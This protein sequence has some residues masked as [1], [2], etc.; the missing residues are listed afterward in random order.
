MASGSARRDYSSLDG[1]ETDSYLDVISMS[2]ATTVKATWH[3][4]GYVYKNSGGNSIT[5][6]SGYISVDGVV[7]NGTSGSVTFTLPSTTN[8]ITVH[9]SATMAYGNTQVTYD[10]NV[11]MYY[12]PITSNVVICTQNRYEMLILPDPTNI[13][14]KIFWIVNKGNT[15]FL[16]VSAYASETIDNFGNNQIQLPQW[17]CVSLTTNGTNWFVLSYYGGTFP[18]YGV[19]SVN[20][21]TPTSNILVAPIASTT[22]GKNIILPNPATWGKGNFFFANCYQT[23]TSAY[24]ISAQFAIYT[25]G[26]LPQN[27]TTGLYLSL[28]PAADDN[29]RYDHNTSIAFVS[30]GT[31]WY[32]ASYFRGENCIFDTNT[33]SAT[34]LTSGILLKTNTTYDFM[35]SAGPVSNYGKLYYAKLTGVKG[36]YGM[37]LNNAGNDTTRGYCG[38]TNYRRVYKNSS[39]QDYVSFT[40]I[41]ANDGTNMINYPVGMYPSAY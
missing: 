13:A 25:N 10:L 38:S 16:S 22:G 4:F 6:T 37:Y 30:D 20:G 31:S 17:G 29:S 7:T 33:Q 1:V 8:A 23:S 9:S 2:N 27:T 41:Q 24:S 21:T 12:T 36:T 34:E 19:Y 32:I 26:Y 35:P 28:Q 11:T 15:T 3:T 14:G 40:F 39:T 18:A 5:G